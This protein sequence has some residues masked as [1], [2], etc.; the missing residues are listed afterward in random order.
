MIQKI[1]GLQDLWQC[2]IFGCYFVLLGRGV[3]AVREGAAGVCR[4]AQAGS[5]HAHKTFVQDLES[6]AA[7]AQRSPC[8][9]C[10]CLTQMF[11]EKIWFR[12][13]RGVLPGTSSESGWAQLW[14]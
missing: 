13:Q 4:R 12:K 11:L 2:E 9:L 3:L 6:R 5:R 14:V 8:L 10:C 7:L 1:P